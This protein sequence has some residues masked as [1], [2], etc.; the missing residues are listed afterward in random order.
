M[1][2]HL[3]AVGGMAGDMFIAAMLDA[4]PHLREPLFDAI[5]VAGLPADV[6]CEVAVDQLARVRPPTSD[7]SQA[8]WLAAH[9]LDDDPH[10]I[11]RQVKSRGQ[12]AAHTGGELRREINRQ[13]L[14][15]P[16][17]DDGMRFHAAVGL[18]LGAI[19]GLDDGIGF[20]EAFVRIAA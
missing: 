15:P 8:E 5:R 1:H 13:P 16:I 17:G 3:D 7:R 10:S 14:R 6:T 4:F 12:F 18:H 2:L 11:A 19:F 20:G 9:G